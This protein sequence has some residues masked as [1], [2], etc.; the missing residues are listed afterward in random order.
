MLRGAPPMSVFSFGEDSDIPPIARI[1][2]A[3]WE[4][5]EYWNRR[6]RAYL[7]GELDPKF[8]LKLRVSY[9][10][11]ERSSIIGF[12][13]GHLTTAIF[14]KG[15]WSGSMSFLKNA[16]AGSGRVT[17]SV[18]R[19]VRRTKRTADL[20]GRRVCECDRASVL[21]TQWS[22]RLETALDGLE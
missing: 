15:N 12:I 2:A 10:C 21:C 8:A 9:V 22:G 1:R 19:M 3:E 16:A 6:I 5:E 20:R 7:A 4:T 11:C 13:A 14:A 17:S 18:R